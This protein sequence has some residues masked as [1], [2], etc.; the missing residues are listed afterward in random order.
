MAYELYLLPLPRGAD[1]EDEGEALLAR[2]ARFDEVPAAGE[3]RGALDEVTDAL[4]RTDADLAD[5]GDA[6]PAT[7]PPRP[8]A[9]ARLLGGGGIE[10][11]VARSFVRVRV[12]FQH[13]GDD[14]DAVFARVFRLLGAAQGATGWTAYDPQ[15]A[16]GVAL[17]DAGREQTL[18]IYLT[19]MDQLRPRPA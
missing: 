10:V 16:D 14:A 11:T 12:P 13:W 7:A 8:V 6:V 9:V 3:D 2:L 18:L 15:D 17:D 1:V 4:R 5:A 19:A